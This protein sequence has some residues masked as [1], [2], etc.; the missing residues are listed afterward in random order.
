MK[1]PS[2][3]EVLAL[4]NAATA[5]DGTMD[6]TMAQLILQLQEQ[7][8]LNQAR[9]QAEATNSRTGSH[10]TPSVPDA[11][12]AFKTDVNGINATDPNSTFDLVPKFA[13]A[14]T[15][16]SPSQAGAASPVHVPTPAPMKRKSIPQHEEGGHSV[17]HGSR[18]RDP[19]QS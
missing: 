13:A 11:V 3:E 15:I 9:A 14:V 1:A 2:A 6:P 19:I 8:A 5:P 10:G 16:E 12:P 7:H 18:K 4:V 17:D